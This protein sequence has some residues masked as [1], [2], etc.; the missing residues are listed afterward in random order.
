MLTLPT[1]SS[2]AAA[3]AGFEHRH[4]HCRATHR[5]GLRV[6][7]VERVRFRYALTESEPQ[8]VGGDPK[9][10]AAGFADGHQF[11]GFGVCGSRLNQRAAE[12]LEEGAT[13]QMTGALFR[14]LTCAAGDHVL[15]ALAATL[16]VVGR[17]EPV[18]RAFHL[19][20]NEPVVVEG[21]QGHDGPISDAAEVRPLRIEPV[22]H[23]VE[24]RDRL[25][26][27]G[28]RQIALDIDIAAVWREAAPP[29]SGLSRWD[30]PVDRD[31]PASLPAGSSTMDPATTVRLPTATTSMVVLCTRAR[32]IERS[33][34]EGGPRV[35]IE[36]TRSGTRSHR[37]LA[38]RSRSV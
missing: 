16:R 11:G 33:L 23:A 15:V 9:T 34:S 1:E 20:K 14:D 12:R 28:R 10:D 25:R 36:N 17:S 35:Q 32:V 22:G 2:D 3:T 8:R 21:I 5:C 26:G 7:G 38:E 19:L 13:R 27:R 18:C 24:A 6:C 31:Q 4:Y 37:A 30:R 29:C